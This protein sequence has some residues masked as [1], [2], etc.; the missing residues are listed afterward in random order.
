[1]EDEVIYLPLDNS[2]EEEI[3]E[4]DSPAS[5]PTAE[6]EPAKEKPSIF[7]GLLEVNASPALK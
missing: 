5:A 1:M 3:V 6:V 2:D 7:D 4:N